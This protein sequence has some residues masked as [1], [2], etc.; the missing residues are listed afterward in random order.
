MENEIWK[1]IPGYEG[2]YEVSNFG[3]VHSLDRTIEYIGRNQSSE[4]KVIRN[5]KGKP[6]KK[7]ID[8]YGYYTVGLNKG[9]GVKRYKLHQ[10]V[11]QAFI[12]NPNNLI[13]IN[14][15]DENKLNNTVDNLEWCTPSYNCNYGTRNERIRKSKN[16]NK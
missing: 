3:N 15:K 2:Y 4:Y 12:P 5:F 14:H 11:A 8:A 6:I 16:H 13:Q 7:Q 1:A 10:L 9:K